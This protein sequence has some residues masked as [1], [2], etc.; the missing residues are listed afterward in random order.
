MINHN[1][2]LELLVYNPETGEFFH[3]VN[4][5]VKKVGGIAG[6][7]NKDKNGH[8]CRRI[9]LDH[10]RYP[11]THL[12]WFYMTKEWPRN[13]IDHI[14]LDS[15]NDRWGNLRDSNHAEQQRNRGIFRNNTSGFKNVS[16]H[17][18]SQKWRVKIN[19]KHIGYYSD[20]EEANQIARKFREKM[21]HEYARHE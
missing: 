13:T 2:L 18:R 14:D 1:R 7:V 12:A 19:G 16:W 9:M 17:E 10:K 5:R 21:N 11:A 3:N 15:L 6:C 4:D 8:K 20:L